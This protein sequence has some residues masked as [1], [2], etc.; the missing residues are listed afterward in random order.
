MSSDARAGG[1]CARHHAAS[2]PARSRIPGAVS[3]RSTARRTGPGAHRRRG[4]RTPTPAQSMR[5]AFSF[6]SPAAGTMTTAQP[7]ASARARVP[8]PPWQT[9][10]SHAGMTRA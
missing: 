7:L 8:W 9:T 10:T 6:M 2:S 1:S 4:T 5:A 3:A